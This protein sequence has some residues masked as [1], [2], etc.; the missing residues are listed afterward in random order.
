VCV[1][2]CVCVCVF[3][4]ARAGIC[5]CFLGIGGREMGEV[6]SCVLQHGLVFVVNAGGKSR[7][8][9][10]QT[11]EQRIKETEEE[12]TEETSTGNFEYGGQER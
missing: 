4:R 12:G 8:C 6:R 5:V 9:A 7:E 2:V 1:C 10:A 3:V 11:D